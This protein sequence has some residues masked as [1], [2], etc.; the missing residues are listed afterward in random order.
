MS[1]SSD[2]TDSSRTNTADSHPTLTQEEYDNREYECVLG[3]YFK[4]GKFVPLANRPPTTTQERALKGVDTVVDV[5]FTAMHTYV[6]VT[7]KSNVDEIK[8]IL[9]DTVDEHLEKITD[10]NTR[11]ESEHLLTFRP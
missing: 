1:K 3:H 8:Q 6:S 5:T 10:D 9:N 11:R 4:D 2:P 7:D